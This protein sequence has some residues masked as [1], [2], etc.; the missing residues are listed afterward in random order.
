MKQLEKAIVV[1]ATLALGLTACDD[2]APSPSSAGTEPAAQVSA[3]EATESDEAGD[4]A[5]E[6][7][8]GEEG[9]ETAGAEAS[10]GEGS[11]S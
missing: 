8:E 1:A 4:P 5:G 9:E 11:C 6:G 3:D 10:C 2:P 7:S